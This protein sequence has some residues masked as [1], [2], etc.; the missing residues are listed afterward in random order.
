MNETLYYKMESTLASTK[1][2]L[3]LGGSSFMGLDLL[4]DLSNTPNCITYMIN[5]G[6]NYW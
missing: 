4:E 3:I 1:Y 5:R 2:V 6:K